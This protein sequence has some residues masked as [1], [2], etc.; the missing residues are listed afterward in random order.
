VFV[1]FKNVVDAPGVTGVGD[2]LK[3]VFGPL[4]IA[5]SEVFETAA[6]N[7]SDLKDPSFLYSG[8]GKYIVTLML[9]SAPGC[10]IQT[11]DTIHVNPLPAVNAGPDKYILLGNSDILS[12]VV[13]EEDLS[14]LWTP[15]LYLSSDTILNPICTAIT[16]QSYTLTATTKAGCS[17]S[18]TVDVKVLA[19]INIPNAF[20]PNGDGINDTWRIKYLEDYPGATLD[21]Y[22]RSGQPVFHS[23][24]YNQEW[25]GTLN[26]KPLPFG[27]YYYIIN[28][29]NKRP[30]FSGSVTIIR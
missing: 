4:T 12:P 16:N 3:F 10:I 1:V 29:K 27:T 6:N 13:S 11:S 14:Y 30:T 7:T 9:Q 17:R 26:G 2:Q 28:P 21:V 23:D 19:A 18:D 24:G 20:S 25:D 5:E 22:D 8:Q 15:A